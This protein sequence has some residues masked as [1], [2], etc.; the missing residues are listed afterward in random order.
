MFTK[1]S[2]E[3]QIKHICEKKLLNYDI[4][5]EIRFKTTEFISENKRA[6]AAIMK[7]KKLI[8]V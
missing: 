2:I 5:S 8:N 1:A 7:L 6:I 4:I 3:T